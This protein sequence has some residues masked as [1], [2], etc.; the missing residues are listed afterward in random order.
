MLDQINT[1]ENAILDTFEAWGFSG[2]KKHSEDSIMDSF[3]LS[4][5]DHS[6][7]NLATIRGQTYDF[8]LATLNNIQN[9]TSKL[10]SFLIVKHKIY[11]GKREIEEELVTRVADDSKDASRDLKDL[12]SIFEEIT[13]VLEG[14]SHEIKDS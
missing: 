7:N 11:E 3:G 12:N 6:A 8:D 10:E 9:A 1:Q 2:Y 14:S 5:G 13:H 4:S